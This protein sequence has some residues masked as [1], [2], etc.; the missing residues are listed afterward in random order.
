MGDRINDKEHRYAKVK[1]EADEL[2]KIMEEQGSGLL[3][4]SVSECKE[5]IIKFEQKSEEK[6][7]RWEKIKQ[8][9]I[10]EEKKKR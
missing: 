9:F 2:V 7:K 10:S 5:S 4:K 3:Y 8:D 6:D 1:A